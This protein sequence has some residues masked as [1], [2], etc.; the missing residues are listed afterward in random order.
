[1][2]WKLCVMGKAKSPLVLAEIQKYA[3]R[4]REV[5]FEIVELKEFKGKSISQNLSQEALQFKKRF[6][7]SDYTWIILAEEGSLKTSQALAHWLESQPKNCVFF[8]GSAYGICPSIKKDAEL[9]LSL[10]PLTFTH[11][12]ARILLVEQLYRALMIQ[13]NHPYHHS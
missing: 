9:L 1:M 13:K 4:L 6:P 10:S 3:Q 12:H 11:D 8:I 7:K 2:N 5:S